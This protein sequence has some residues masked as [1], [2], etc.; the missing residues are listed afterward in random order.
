M[1]S[2]E[3]SNHI[4]DLVPWDFC[5]LYLQ[6]KLHRFVHKAEFICWSYGIRFNITILAIIH[7]IYAIAGP[8]AQ[9]HNNSN[10]HNLLIISLK[11]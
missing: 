1:F 9:M 6:N 10:Q 3:H 5:K 2:T 8:E 4:C 7:I 11:V